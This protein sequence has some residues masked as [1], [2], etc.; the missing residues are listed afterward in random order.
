MLNIT[1]ET[2]A[3]LVE[4]TA[5]LLGIIYVI[6][7]SRLKRNCWIYGGIST[8]LFTWLFFSINLYIDSVLNAYYALMAIVGWFS[9]KSIGT[10]IKVSRLSGFELITAIFL[11]LF[12][13][14]VLAWIMWKYTDNAYP[15]ADSFLGALSV[16]ATWLSTRKKIENWPFWIIANLLGITIYLLKE[17]YLTSFLTCIYAGLATHGWYNWRIKLKGQHV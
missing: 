1:P 15:V 8:L 3:F 5:V 2:A 14:S 7:A 4:W 17:L 10:E 16:T 6:Q 13:G 11:T 12:I 9:W